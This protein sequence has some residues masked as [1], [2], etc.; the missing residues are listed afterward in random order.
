MS[1]PDEAMA[2]IFPRPQPPPGKDRHPSIVHTGCV[3]AGQ[4]TA[5]NRRRRFQVFQGG[6]AGESK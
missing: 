3:E 4:P 2:E 5:P 1:T 6:K